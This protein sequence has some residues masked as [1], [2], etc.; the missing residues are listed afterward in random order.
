MGI[1]GLTDYAIIGTRSNIGRNG[2]LDTT[3]TKVETLSERPGTY[4]HLLLTQG[5]IPRL[6]TPTLDQGQITLPEIDCSTVANV[7]R[8]V[9][10]F[11]EHE[12]STL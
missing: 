8:R 5:H 10:G 3:R 12:Q 1:D 7:H 6:K 9:I 2:D 11:P 4:K